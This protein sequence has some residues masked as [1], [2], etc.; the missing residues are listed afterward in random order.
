[1]SLNYSISNIFEAK[2]WS[3]RDS[4]AKNFGSY[5]ALHWL[6]YGY[7]QKGHFDNGNYNQLEIAGLFW[8][9]VDLVWI[10]LFPIMY[11]M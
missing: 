3:K 4:T 8:H 11:L 10:F 9:F 7:L 5:H 1:M 6:M 2:Y